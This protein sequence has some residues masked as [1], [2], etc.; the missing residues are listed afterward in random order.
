MAFTMLLS[1]AFAGSFSEDFGDTTNSCGSEWVADCETGW[2]ASGEDESLEMA[3]DA[4][5]EYGVCMEG[6]TTSPNGIGK[7][8]HL[9]EDDDGL[10][11]W[12]AKL[13]VLSGSGSIQVRVKFKNSAGLT[14]STHT[15]TYSVDTTPEEYWVEIGR[16]IPENAHSVDLMVGATNSSLV[17]WIDQ[18]DFEDENVPSA[19]TQEECDDQAADSEKRKKDACE[20]RN[21][22]FGGSCSATPDSGHPSGCLLVCFTTCT[23]V[24]LFGN[25]SQVSC[26]GV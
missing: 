7:S 12:T 1:L 23:A 3:N 6:G 15:E 22:T 4:S 26:L 10:V 14:I 18:L 11:S 17:A 13:G 16:S 19:A 8:T 20:D 21:G 25:L 24:D 2:N 9:L 5:S